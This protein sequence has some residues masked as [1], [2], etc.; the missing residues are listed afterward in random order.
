MSTPLYELIERAERMDSVYSERYASFSSEQDRRAKQCIAEAREAIEEASASNRNNR[1]T[2]LKERSKFIVKVKKKI[3]YA[4]ECCICHEPIEVG[5]EYVE[6]P[7]ENKQCHIDCMETE[8]LKAVLSFFGIPSC[9]TNSEGKETR[10][11][12]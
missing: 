10:I 2:A 8:P 4:G 12:G 6:A 5:E 7:Y 3:R 1:P 11:Y 9:V